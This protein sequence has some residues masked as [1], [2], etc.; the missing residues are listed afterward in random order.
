M[1]ESHRLFQFDFID[2]SSTKY[3]LSREEKKHMLINYMK[4]VRRSDY[5]ANKGFL[6]NNVDTILT[7]YEVREIAN[8]NPVKGFP[9]VFYQFVNNDKYY[10]LGSKFVDRPTEAMLEEMNVIRRKGE[11]HR[12]YMIQYAVM[13]YTAINENCINPEDKTCVTEIPK[14]IDAI[15]GKTIKLKKCHISDAVNQ[16]KGSYF[17]N[18]PNQRSYR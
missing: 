9:L 15:Y 6:D 18:I 1:F 12:K 2:L 14:I 4:R 13:V 17:I 7:Q 5:T 11:E 16:L 8:E 10:R 3:I